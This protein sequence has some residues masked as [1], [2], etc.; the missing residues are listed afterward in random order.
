MQ[1]P[2]R[3]EIRPPTKRNII[4]LTIGCSIFVIAGL[5]LITTGDVKSIFVGLLSITFFGGIGL[6]GIPKLSRRSISV[7]LTHDNLQQITPFGTSIVPWQDVESIGVAKIH[8]HKMVGIRLITY[9]NYIKNTSPELA[10]STNKKLPYL[11]VLAF[12]TSLLGSSAGNMKSLGQVGNLVELMLWNR[13][14]CGYDIYFSWMDIDRSV[15]DF[16]QLLEQ[17]HRASKASHE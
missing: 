4:L 11:K 14:N 5:L 12:G 16:V 3:L 2:P 8:R 9:D 6:V 10:E 17:F 15:S 7:V 1:L 13:Q